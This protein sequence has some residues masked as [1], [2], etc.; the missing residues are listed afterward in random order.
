MQQFRNNVHTHLQTLFAS[1]LLVTRERAAN[2]RAITQAITRAILFSLIVC[3]SGLASADSSNTAPLNLSPRIVGGTPID[4]SQ[5]PA[6]AALLR[7]SKV[8]LDG[9]LFQAQFCG[10]TVIA[11]RWVLT[12]AHCIVNSLGNVSAPQA[13]LVLTGSTDLANPVNQPI[14]VIKVVTHPAFKSVELGFDIALLE[15]A[16]DAMVAPIVLDT[17]DIEPNQRA[18]IAGW[19]AVNDADEG[20][21]QLFPTILRGTFVNMTPGEICGSQFP[22][23]AGYTDETNIC[24]GVVEGGKDTCQGDSGGPMYRVNNNDNSILAITGITSWGVGCGVARN[25]GVYT[26]VRSYTG[27]VRSVMGPDAINQAPPP[28]NDSPTAPVDSDT[29]LPNQQP[30]DSGYRDDADLFAAAFSPVG[31]MLL[32]LILMVRI[33]ITDPR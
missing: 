14:E 16:Y 33:R 17:L 25:P 27:W 10:G 11:A 28:V 22:D 2:A 5:V 29:P 30:Q 26:N 24:A 15:L 4:I 32:M 20:K 18:F 12:A 7:T 19:G 8:N 1:I 31:G 13:I 9:D 3:A 23:Y 21:D 6:T